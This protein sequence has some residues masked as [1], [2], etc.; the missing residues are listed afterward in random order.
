MRVYVFA[1]VV[2]C[3]RRRV[4]MYVGEHAHSLKLMLMTEVAP[5]MKGIASQAVSGVFESKMVVYL[6]IYP[7]WVFCHS[8]NRHCLN[9]D[10]CIRPLPWSV[11]N[12]ESTDEKLSKFDFAIIRHVIPLRKVFFCDDCATLEPKL[13]VPLSRSNLKCFHQLN[14][15]SF[16]CP[17][18]LHNIIKLSRLK[19]PYA[20]EKESEREK[21]NRYTHNY[22]TSC[23]LL[24]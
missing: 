5:R 18:C 10:R 4:C 7:F 2:G 15:G 14:F 1:C 24:I 20:K 16:G 13:S 21:T 6:S 11:A 19:S 22:W 8:T 3:A 9:V 12:V 17:T 23:F